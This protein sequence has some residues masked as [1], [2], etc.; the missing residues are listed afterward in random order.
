MKEIKIKSIKKLE[1]ENDRYDLTVNKNR[2]FFA[3]NILIHNTSGRTGLLEQELQLT[4]F[5]KWWNKHFPM[6]FATHEWKYVSGSRNVVFDP[7]K[8]QMVGSPR[9]Y[10]AEIHD[11][12]KYMGLH[13]GETIYYEI[14]G[15]T[16]TGKLIMGSHGINDKELK[17]KYGK[18]MSYRYGCQAEIDTSNCYEGC[19]DKRFHSQYK[20][21]VYRM[22]RTGPDGQKYEVPY[23]QMLT[24][25]KELALEV[26]PQVYPPF[27]YNG[28]RTALMELCDEL[29]LGESLSDRTHIKEGIVVR[30]EAPNRET[31]LKHKSFKFLVLEDRAK[32]NEEYVDAEEIA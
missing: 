2:N 29:T 32:E 3:N 17:K 8:K 15:H 12:F 22:T 27:I 14:V 7:D 6:K 18:T 26:V 19:D 30:V 28:D 31:F 9:D 23:A 5:K 13:K 24:R 16:N 20:A 21:L 25:V 10:R 11:I 4:K 1:K